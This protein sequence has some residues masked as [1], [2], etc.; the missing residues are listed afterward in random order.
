MLDALEVQE[1]TTASGFGLGPESE[2]VRASLL[3]HEH[4]NRG[5]VRPSPSATET[6]LLVGC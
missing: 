6:I 4:R 3:P 5:L 2:P 1:R